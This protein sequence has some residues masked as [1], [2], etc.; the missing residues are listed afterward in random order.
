[1]ILQAY[2]GGTDK[3]SPSD[4][5]MLKQVKTGD[6]IKFDADNVNGALTVMKMDK[7]K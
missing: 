2:S 1:M 3:K 5:A 6:K 4:A 7:V